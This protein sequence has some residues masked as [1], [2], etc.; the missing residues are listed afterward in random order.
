VGR[1]DVVICDKLDHA[2]IVDGCLLSSAKF[3][4]FQHNEMEGLEEKLAN[5]KEEDCARL[6]V[7]DAVFSMDGDIAPLPQL[8]EL[9]QKYQAW[10]MVDEPILWESLVQ[11]GMV[12]RNTSL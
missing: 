11:L 2:S 9:C 12:L 7:V 4:R 8:A 6:V 1:N 3:L 5:Y 10:L